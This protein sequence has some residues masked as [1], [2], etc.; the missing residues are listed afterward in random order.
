MKLQKLFFLAALLCCCA[1]LSA[2]SYAFGVKGGMT[3][4]IQQWD[5]FER[6][7]LYK[8][9]GIVFIETAEEDSPFSIFGQLGYHV[10]GSAIRT[11]ETVFNSPTGLR[12]FPATT[13]EFQFKNVSLTV[14]GKRKY[15]LGSNSDSKIYY[16]LGVRA[17]YT[18]GTN[19]GSF[20]ESTTFATFYFN[21]PVEENVRKFNYGA[22]IG[23]GIELPLSDF[24]SANIELTANPDFSRQ[25]YREPINN[26]IL[27]GTGSTNT[28]NLPEQT[29]RNLTLELT[30]GFRFLRQ[31]EYIDDDEY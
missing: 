27:P 16:L 21:R 13:Q 14:G 22:T 20:E 24:V 4:G 23:G 3:V 19:L 30:V 2:Q 12:T 15:D 9:H 17:D 29:I 31:I 1:E 26:V 8:Y 7:P 28:T 10:K 11:Q 6:D 18:V 25:Y 5:G